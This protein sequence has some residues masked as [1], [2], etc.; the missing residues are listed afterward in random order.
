MSEYKCLNDLSFFIQMEL[1]YLRQASL[2]GENSVYN[3]Y[4]L[5]PAMELVSDPLLC[6]GIEAE[7]SDETV[8]KPGAGMIF[9]DWW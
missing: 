2:A 5:N 8:W 7:R 1:N 3:V 9:F 6:Q 4:N